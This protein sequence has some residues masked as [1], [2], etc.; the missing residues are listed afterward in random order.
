[1]RCALWLVTVP[2][3]VRTLDCSVPPIAFTEPSQ[4]DGSVYC[5]LAG[6]VAKLSLTGRVS[7]APPLHRT[8]AC[9]TLASFSLMGGRN[10]GVDRW[11]PGFIERAGLQEWSRSYR[12]FQVHIVL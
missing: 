12:T 11:E 2:G 6:G 4:R 9:A 3:V 5:T 10:T 7:L 1:M 8:V